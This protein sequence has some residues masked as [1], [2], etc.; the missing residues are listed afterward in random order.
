M[1]EIIVPFTYTDLPAPVAAELRAVTARIKDRLTRQVK[2][3]IETGRDLL[4][5]K[6]KLEHGQ[7]ESWLDSEFGMTVRTAQRFMRASE[8][9]Q[10]KND[11]VSH[12]TPTTVYMLS[13]KSTPKGVHEQVVERLERGLPAESEYVRH[14][15]Q[16]ARIRESE[17]KNRKGLREARDARKRRESQPEKI[18]NR[19]ERQRA[20]ARAEKQHKKKEQ[21][22]R[23][24]LVINFSLQA[25]DLA[26]MLVDNPKSTARPLAERTEDEIDQTLRNFDITY[27]RLRK[28]IMESRQSHSQKMTVSPP[29]PWESKS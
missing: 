7:F 20:I 19:R 8:W 6:S 13:A 25:K 10:D 29:K 5:V 4:E 3:I 24:S 28:A 17:A 16:E 11:I 14:V 1:N 22:E 9:A 27:K 15:V 18:K 26:I 2:D 12:L 23:E 21:S